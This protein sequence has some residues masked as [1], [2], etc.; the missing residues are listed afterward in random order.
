MP[1]DPWAAKH[2]PFDFATMS[3]PLNGNRLDSHVGP[4]W[5]RSLLRRRQSRF[6]LVALLCS[7]L[8]CFLWFVGLVSPPVAVL[9]SS[10]PAESTS[11]AT[12]PINDPPPLYEQWYEFERH[13]PQQNES[14]PYPEGADAR[15]FYASNHVWGTFVSSLAGKPF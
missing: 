9:K 3:L 5:L 11:Q 10:E 1:A 4:T 2:R 7:F 14:L 13:L 8:L 6:F 12:P 15:F